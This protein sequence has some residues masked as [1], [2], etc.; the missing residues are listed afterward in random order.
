MNSNILD[1]ELRTILE[2]LADGLFPL[3]DWLKQK[4]IRYPHLIQANLPWRVKGTL[5]PKDLNVI[6]FFA[7]LLQETPEEAKVLERWKEVEEDALKFSPVEN[8]QVWRSARGLEAKARFDI[9]E[10][11]N[12]LSNPDGKPTSRLRFYAL[13]WPLLKTA[14]QVRNPQDAEAWK[15]LTND[16]FM[17]KCIE[18]EW[19]TQE[20]KSSGFIKQFGSDL[21]YVMMDMRNYNP[22]HPEDSASQYQVALLTELGESRRVGNKYTSADVQRAREVLQAKIRG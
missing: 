4:D 7:A 15:A 21:L 17:D 12:I 14:V 2:N 1:S 5:S 3:T 19:S 22:E 8:P 13:Y 10:S 16:L 6:D 9:V 20:P 11:E 18:Q